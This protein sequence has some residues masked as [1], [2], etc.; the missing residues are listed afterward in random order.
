MTCFD[1]NWFDEYPI[2]FNQQNTE[3]PFGESTTV[4]FHI[5][6]V[7]DSDTTF[8]VEML[9]PLTDNPS[10]YQHSRFVSQSETALRQRLAL[11]L[12]RHSM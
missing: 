11:S 12:Q 7:R 10:A 1:N 4:S 3:V 6:N 2:I 9:D 5:I 8:E